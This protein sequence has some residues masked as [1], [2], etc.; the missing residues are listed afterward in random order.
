MAHSEGWFTRD[1]RRLLAAWA[2]IACALP[3]LAQIPTQSDTQGS[4]FTSQTTIVVVPALVRT[5]AGELVYTL[6]ADDFHLTDD[7]VRQKLT[8][9]KESGNE[10]LALVVVVQVGGAGARQ[11]QKFDTIAP[12]LAPMLS[13][14]VGNVYHQVA[15]VTF[16]SHPTLLQGFTSDVDEASDALR[17][18]KPGC[19]RHNHYD[20]CTG[21]NPV[22]DV[23]LGDNGAAI[24]D[25]LA[26]A[27]NLLRAEPIGY[28]RAILLISETLDRGSETTVEQAVRAVTD[29]NTTIYSIGFSTGKSEANAYAHRQLPMSPQTVG[30]G[31]GLAFENPHPNP[32]N[33]CMGKDP[34][35]FPDAP[36]S[37]WSQFYDCV[38]QLVPPLTFMK[39]AAIATADSLQQNV[40]ATV[41]RLSGGEYFKLT[42]VK[43]LEQSLSTI[44]NHLPNRYVL[45]FHPESPR[46]GLHAIR[47]RLPNYEGLEVSARTSYWSDPILT[48][49]AQ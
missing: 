3:A 47:L 17:T 45:S 44:G 31:G 32:P 46:P 30:P 25:S 33:G 43:S 23:P 38:A 15:V 21:S 6:K 4:I 40:P 16:D 14:I 18:L 48:T 34:N 39:M 36:N 20:N 11:F 8:L 49:A 42:D 24:L 2:A 41:A 7:G 10:P 29:T 26:F 13:S 37:K 27:V 35:P 12:P 19:T 9:E 28:R 5:K 1:L 22:H